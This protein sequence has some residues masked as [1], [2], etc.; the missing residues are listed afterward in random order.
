MRRWLPLVGGGGAA[1]ASERAFT[2]DYYYRLRRFYLYVVGALSV[3]SNNGLSSLGQICSL[4]IVANMLCALL[5]L[6]QAV[7]PAQNRIALEMPRR[8]VRRSPLLRRR[9][10]I[11]WMA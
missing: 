5:L 10:K 1:A 3:A 6:P 8:T 11:M 4:G 2:L 7:D 9:A